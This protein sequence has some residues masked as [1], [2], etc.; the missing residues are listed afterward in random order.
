MKAIGGYF[1]LE[2]PKGSE[3][4]KKAIAL[5]SGRH[6]FEYIL[7]LRK[8]IKVYLPYYTCEVILEPIKKLN[9][10]YEYYHIN[11]KLEPHFD[12]SLLQENEAF[13]YTNY[14]GLKDKYINTLISKH[15]IIIDNCQAFFSYPLPYFNTFYSPRK[16]FGVPD[17][18]YLYIYNNIKLDMRLKQAKS[19]N[20][21]SHLL[22]RIDLS[23]EKGYSDFKKNDF[24]ISSEPLMEMSKLT[25]RLLSSIDYK[26]CKEKRQE[27]FIW[28]HNQLKNI[29]LLDIDSLINNEEVPMIYPLLIN[30]PHLREK[31]IDKNIFIPQYWKN[32]FVW[33]KKSDYEQYLTRC[34]IPLPIDQRLKKQDLNIIKNSVLKYME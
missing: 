27:N 6:C 22:K 16:F 20:K 3:Y 18:G 10:Q 1:E 26:Y 17:G 2:L 7:R 32:V 12:F 11:E 29:N 15:N 31:L 33:T 23:A 8:Y 19:Y 5:N 25:H 14:F 13:L 21:C 4:H 24:K 34:L 30:K 28:L 9:L